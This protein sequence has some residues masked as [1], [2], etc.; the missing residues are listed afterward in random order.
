MPRAVP[1]EPNVP[2]WHVRASSGLCEHGTFA[3]RRPLVHQHFCPAL[4]VVVAMLLVFG[5]TAHVDTERLIEALVS[6]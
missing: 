5:L 3:H 2:L 1:H 6:C 4:F